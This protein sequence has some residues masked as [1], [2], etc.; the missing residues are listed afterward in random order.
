M[1]PA[2]ATP[3]P[4]EP[5]PKRAPVPSEAVKLRAQRTEPERRKVR[6]RRTLQLDWTGKPERSEGDRRSR[7][8]RRKTRLT[9]R[10]R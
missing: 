2:N 1:N 3:A 5:Q 8:D 6:E 10:Q 9:F 4:E 7:R